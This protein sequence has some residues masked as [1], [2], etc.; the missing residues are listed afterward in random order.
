MKNLKNLPNKFCESPL[1]LQRKT[2]LIFS[3]SDRPLSSLFGG[4][5][6]VVTAGLGHVTNDVTSYRQSLSSC[7]LDP[8]SFTFS[9][10]GFAGSVV[11]LPDLGVTLTIPEGALDRGYTEEIFLA[12]MT[13][14][15]DRPRLSDNQV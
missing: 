8:D 9:S 2:L 5:S 13:E 4:E 11:T 14:G 7:S 12:V 15:R 10:V 3:E 6:N 1:D